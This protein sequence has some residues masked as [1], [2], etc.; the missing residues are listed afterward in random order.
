MAKE[1]SEASLVFLNENAEK[2]IWFVNL[3]NNSWKI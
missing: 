2:T 1:F 3:K